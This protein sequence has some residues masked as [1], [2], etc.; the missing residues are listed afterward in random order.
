M[1]AQPGGWETEGK[2]LWQQP[3]LR[4]REGRGTEE[5]VRGVRGEE[6]GVSVAGVHT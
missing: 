2:H 5:Q 3:L 4:V 1:W 6:D